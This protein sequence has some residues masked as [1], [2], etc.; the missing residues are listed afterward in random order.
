MTIAAVGTGV[1]TAAKVNELI[2]AINANTA[3][4]ALLQPARIGCQIRRPSQ[5]LSTGVA[6]TVSWDTQDEDTD[7]FFAPTSTTVTIPV[8][9]GGIYAVTYRQILSGAPTGRVFAEMVP[10]SSTVGMPTDLRAIGN[11]SETGRVVLALPSVPFT[12]GDSFIIN[13]I[14]TSAGT[15]T[16]TA[17]LTLYR[18]ST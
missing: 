10:T 11:T 7:N 3:A 6:T 8:G 17:W 12:A 9:L 15:L 14:Q 1:A 18:V 16:L 4:V 2:T 5:S 13:T